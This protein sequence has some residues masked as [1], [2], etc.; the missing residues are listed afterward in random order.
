MMALEN[1]KLEYTDS[2]VKTFKYNDYLD[3][4]KQCSFIVNG[5]RIDNYIEINLKPTC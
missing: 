3:F 4:F 5:E 2:I 1:L